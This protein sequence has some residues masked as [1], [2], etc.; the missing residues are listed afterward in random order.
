MFRY[1][2]SSAVITGEGIF[3]YCYVSKEEAK[4]WLAKG[5]FEN[6]LGYWQT[7]E[8]FTKLFGYPT[9]SERRAVRMAVGDEALIFRLKMRVENVQDKGTMTVDEIIKNL[10]IGLLKKEGVKL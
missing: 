9:V 1:V 8:A 10:E 4:E 5:G 2:L 7:A 6:Y 3:S